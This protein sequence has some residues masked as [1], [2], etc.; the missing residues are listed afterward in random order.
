M[1]KDKKTAKK[2]AK[3]VSKILE[4]MKLAKEAQN[5]KQDKPVWDSV[6]TATPNKIRPSKKRG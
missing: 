4:D 1:A 2:V 3:K 6:K 5:Q